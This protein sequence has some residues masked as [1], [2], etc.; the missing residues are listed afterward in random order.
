MMDATRD[1][2]TADL[3]HFSKDT[4]DDTSL[5]PNPFD[6]DLTG[7]PIEFQHH[8]SHNGFAPHQSDI[9]FKAT[10]GDHPTFISTSHM[11]NI[12]HTTGSFHGHP[13][14]TMAGH[15]DDASMTEDLDGRSPS[16]INHSLTSPPSS[17]PTSAV[18]SPTSSSNPTPS[19]TSSGSSSFHL[20]SGLTPGKFELGTTTKSSPSTSTSSSSTRSGRNVRAPTARSST[21][22]KKL[23]S[24]NI[25]Y[26]VDPSSGDESETSKQTIVPESEVTG[27][28]RR[29]RTAREME[30]PSSI[31]STITSSVLAAAAAAVASGA[32]VRPAGSTTLSM[33]NPRLPGKAAQSEAV[34]AAIAKAAELTPITN[35]N[36]DDSEDIRKERNKNSA[37]QY[38]KR[39]KVFVELLEEKVADLEIDNKCLQDRVMELER[40][41]EVLIECLMSQHWTYEVTNPFSKALLM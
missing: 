21:R 35:P 3:L 11:R 2:T 6:R 4:L 19:F 13:L 15:S 8:S 39:R 14:T 41:L 29:K 40:Q 9:A 10:Q 22:A 26:V 23:D 34:K 7:C 36:D 32:P 18:N 24:R 17:P 27:I 37:S 5:I 12:P 28:G 38:R 33:T 30:S 25:D 16:S 20:S 31:V 1:L